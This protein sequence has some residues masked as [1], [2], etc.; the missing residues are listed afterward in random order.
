MKVQKSLLA[1]VIA[2]SVATST[3]M[4]LRA[5]ETTKAPVPETKKPTARTD[6]VDINTASPEQLKAI[7]GLNDREVKKII[8]GRP[9]SRRNELVTKKIITQETY[10][11]IKQ[12]ISAKNASKG[13]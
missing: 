8:D 11:K 4:I 3:P 7:Q 1:A 10:D 13:S 2:V 5:A 9:Y 12:Q 6:R